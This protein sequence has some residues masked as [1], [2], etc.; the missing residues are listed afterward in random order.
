[1]K[2]EDV[3]EVTIYESP[4]GVPRVQVKADRVDRAEEVAKVYKA[5]KKELKKEEDK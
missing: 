2:G 1:M 3:V 5:V 4:D